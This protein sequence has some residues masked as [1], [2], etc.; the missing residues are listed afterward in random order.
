VARRFKTIQEFA[1][2]VSEKTGK[3]ERKKLH[4]KENVNYLDLKHLDFFR[5]SSCIS[6]KLL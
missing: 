6:D 5:S 4:E 2:V 1:T 3:K